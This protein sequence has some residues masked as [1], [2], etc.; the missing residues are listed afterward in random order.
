MLAQGR[1]NMKLIPQE[2]R[3]PYSELDE[4]DKWRLSELLAVGGG[5]FAMILQK[6]PD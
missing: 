2:W 4:W 3:A 1:E 5:S 6:Q